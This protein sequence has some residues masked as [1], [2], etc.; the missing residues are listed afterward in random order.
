MKHVNITIQLTELEAKAS[1]ATPAE[2]QAWRT[3][4]TEMARAR[5]RAQGKYKTAV[6]VQLQRLEA[7]RNRA[8]E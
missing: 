6:H 8:K 5:E 1:I 3:W 4:Y 2:Q 7:D